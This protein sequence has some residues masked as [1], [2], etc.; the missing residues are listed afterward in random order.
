MVAGMYQH[1]AQSLRIDAGSR[2]HRELAPLTSITTALRSIRADDIKIHAILIGVQ[3]SCYS[4]EKIFFQSFFMLITVQ[5]FS[6][7]SA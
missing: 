1:Y 3:L 7:A 4:N 6:F 5:F 2:R